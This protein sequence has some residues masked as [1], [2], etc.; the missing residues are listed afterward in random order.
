MIPLYR[1]YHPRWHRERMPI[2]WWIRKGSYVRFIAR[3]LTSVA[4]G[5][6]A[7][8]LVGLVAAVGRG[9]PAYRRFLE[10][11]ASPWAIALHV[12]VLAALM[13]HTVTWLNLAPQAMVVKLRGRRLP[14]AAVVAAHYGAWLALT[15]A[16]VF[17]V[18]GA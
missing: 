15:A 17:L 6:T 1:P 12:L 11:L 16:I 2:F 8:A 3:E 9:E 7:L 4:V 10:L 18:A 14:D 13:F 5:W